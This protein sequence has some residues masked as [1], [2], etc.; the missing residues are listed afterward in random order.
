L[1]GFCILVPDHHFYTHLLIIHTLLLLLHDHIYTIQFL[2][3]LVC[4]FF[5][6][7]IHALVFQPVVLFVGVSRDG[8]LVG[9]LLAEVRPPTT[10]K[11][12]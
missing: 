2:Y 3:A 8:V 4:F 9:F 5:C 6:C 10:P 12:H 11:P 7:F 1:L